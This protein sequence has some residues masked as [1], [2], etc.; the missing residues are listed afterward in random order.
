MILNY[1]HEVLAPDLPTLSYSKDFATSM[2]VYSQQPQ[3]SYKTLPGK[4]TLEISPKLQHQIRFHCDKISKV[5]WSGVLFYTTEGGTYGDAD[6]KVIAQELYLMD[7]DTPA[8][9]S[10]KFDGP[11]V[12]MLMENPH[13]RNMKKGHVHSH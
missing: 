6:F 5:E 10:Y 8:F 12:K 1:P 9:T 11:F 4:I 2:P 13:L 3:L 7:I